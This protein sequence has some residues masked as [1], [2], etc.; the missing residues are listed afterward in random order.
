MKRKERRQGEV[1]G[2]MMSPDV[3]LLRD[4][5][6]DDDGDWMEGTAVMADGRGRA[7]S[8]GRDV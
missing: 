8:R 2:E 4:D 7:R 3:A 5:D 6:A 1:A